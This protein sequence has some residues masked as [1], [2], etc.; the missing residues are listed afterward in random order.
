MLHKIDQKYKIRSKL[1]KPFAIDINPNIVT[2]IALLVGMGAGAFFYFNMLEYAVL[3]LFL[4]GF[5]DVLDGEIARRRGPTVLGD[6][7]D[8][9]SDRIVDV[10][11]L[12]GIALGG[13][14]SLE[15][16]MYTIIAVLMV[17]YLGTQ[18]QAVSKVR[19]Y[20]GFMGRATRL[21]LLIGFASA[22]IFY[23][24]ILYEGILVMLALSLITFMQR[25][26]HIFRELK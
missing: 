26:I 12:L 11:I 21:L 22:E 7:L 20:K 16:G 24:G 4:N 23:S 18:A 14:V 19:L 10:A 9:I 13:Y 25:F 17:S 8:H 5:F 6:F 1:L 3:F 15:I 2:F